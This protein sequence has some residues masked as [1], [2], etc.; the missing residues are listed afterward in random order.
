MSLSRKLGEKAEKHAKS[1]SHL[2]AIAALQMK[3]TDVVNLQYEQA[4][5]QA[6]Q[7]E[8]CMKLLFKAVYFLF[9]T[10]NPHTTHWSS[11]LSTIAQCDSCGRL[12]NFLC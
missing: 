5:K 12:R 10:E 2:A 11:L 4:N 9:S 6:V 7:D 8:D 1:S 3:D